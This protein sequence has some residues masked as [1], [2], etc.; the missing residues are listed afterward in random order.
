MKPASFADGRAASSRHLTVLRHR[1]TPGIGM[2]KT[3]QH[4]VPE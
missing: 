2:A 4:W 1:G 3:P